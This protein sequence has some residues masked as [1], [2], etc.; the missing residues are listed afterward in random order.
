MKI[1]KQ[2]VHGS[3]PFR[4]PLPGPVARFEAFAMVSHGTISAKEMFSE[5]YPCLLMSSFI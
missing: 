3:L 4:L 1:F 2:V 5:E